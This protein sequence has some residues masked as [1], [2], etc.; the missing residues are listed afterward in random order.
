[1]MIKNKYKVLMRKHALQGVL[2]GAVIAALIVL[3]SLDSSHIQSHNNALG[4]L[5]TEF[6]G[7][8]LVLLLP[9]LG[10]FG[11]YYFSRKLISVVQNRDKKIKKE[12]GLTRLALSFINNVLNN[13]LDEP[14]E[15][16]EGEDN[17]LTNGLVDL[18]EHLIKSKSEEQMRRI[19]DQQ[20][21]WVTQGLAQFG[22]ILRKSNDNIEELSYNILR[23]LVNYV[24]V[25]QG[26]VFLVNESKSREKFFEMTSC[27]AY[28]RRKYADKTIK[29][30]EG[31][32]GRC[33]LEKETIFI[34]D[35]PDNYINITSGLGDSNPGTILLVPLKTTE[36]LF[37]VIELASFR[38][39]QKFEIEFVERT[40]ESI[41]STISTVKNNIQTNKLLR[42]TQIQAEKMAQQEEEL[43]QN[44]E[45]M[46]ATQEESDRREIER[47]GILE[48]ID[49]AA[50]STEFDIDG[51]LLSVN[52]NFL[53]AF[54]YKAE[55]VEGHNIR[56]FFFKDDADSLSQI[57]SDL[58]KGQTFK[59]RV[60]R[61]TKTGEKIYLFSTYSP[62]I[63][64]NGDVI[65]ILTLENDVTDQ[66]KMEEALK[67]SKEE[68]GMLLEEARNEVKEQFKEVEIIKVRNELTL[69]G[70]LDAIITIDKHGT[71]EFFNAAAEKLWG[72]GR[73]EV[74]GQN[75]VILFSDETA[76]N[77]PF[78]TKLV[79]S[80]E[81][82]V[83]GER[84]EIPIKNKF[85]EEVSVLFLL[86][87]AHVGDAHSVTAFIQNIEV[88]L[89]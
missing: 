25:N 45:E 33:A 15:Q 43:R 27:I 19:E 22:E 50:I 70:A 36:Q 66:V 77:I 58:N 1:M 83:I 2:S 53:N 44:L 3:I 64:H 24:K 86:S 76:Q 69:E 75:I 57:L 10:G 62:V 30:G 17:D 85:G 51:T 35:V 73:S 6:P 12:A 40:A 47:K 31:L 41:A 67:N 14:I 11:G 55:E 48:A 46:R 63:D 16:K 5:F 34:T 39:L 4:I 20:R 87:E 81:P 59:G 84:R 9:V 42:E 78:V 82:K 88:E 71:V 56:I 26:G 38:V 68:L 32:I 37:G 23:Y 65:K 79:T 60:C 89:F 74:L 54:R 52:E 80:G 18:R 13:N 8:W 61:R 49:T 21:N 7:L 28:D 72:Y 29:W